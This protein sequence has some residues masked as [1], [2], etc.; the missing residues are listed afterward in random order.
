MKRRTEKKQ[1]TTTYNIHKVI[2]ITPFDLLNINNKS[3]RKY[4]KLLSMQI[5]FHG[6]YSTYSFQAILLVTKKI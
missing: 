4:T 3:K 6:D 1:N 2:Y 5:I